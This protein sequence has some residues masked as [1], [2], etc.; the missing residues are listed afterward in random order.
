MNNENKDLSALDFGKNAVGTASSLM[1]SKITSVIIL[2]LTFIF[3]ARL[4]GSTN[5][6]I[7]VLATAIIGLF[8]AIGNFGIGSAFNRFSAE[9]RDEPEKVNHLLINGFLILLVI[10]LILSSLIFIFS[11]PLSIYTLHTIKYEYVL[12]YI[13]FAVLTSMLFGASYPILIGLGK[14]KEAATSIFTQAIVQGVVSIALILL[15]FG[16]LG[17]IIGLLSGYLSSFVITIIFLISLK[18]YH[19]VLPSIAWLKELFKFTIP[20]AISNIFYSLS[21]NLS[22]VLLGVFTTAVILGNFGIA[23]KI[24]YIYDILLGSISLSLI[25]TFTLIYNSKKVKSRLGEIYSYS[26][27]LAMLFATPIAIFI[28]LFSH[29]LIYLLF[30]NTYQLAPLYIQ[31][32]SLGIMIGILPSFASTLLISIKKVKDMMKN[33]IKIAIIE[34]IIMPFAIYEFSGLGLV[35]L[36]FFIAPIISSLLFITTLKK[37]VKLKI[38]I[39]KILKLIIA[40]IISVAIAYL[41]ASNINYS[42]LQIIIGII[43]VIFI[44]PITLNILN[45]LDESDINNLNR[46]SEN[47]VIV[48]SMLKFIINYYEKFKFLRLSR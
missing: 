19:F 23:F 12:H 4:L 20:I 44:Y 26:V 36:L 38:E 13:S 42:S 24:N 34:I 30:G 9:Y 27:F 1:I 47:V 5:Y 48:N 41:L 29:S 21:G 28:I 11:G 32:I 3:V 16:V 33:N 7:Y 14:R 43:L 35:V 22:T 15:G 17:P 40:S 8:D 37:Y 45:A 2:G 46:L 39:N 25:S 18:K 6:G 10:G 31:I